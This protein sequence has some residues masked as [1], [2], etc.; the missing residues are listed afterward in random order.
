MQSLLQESNQSVKKFAP[1]LG[2][3]LN[4]C[5]NNIS[6]HRKHVFND[7][8]Q[9]SLNY[10]GILTTVFNPGFPKPWIT[11]T[12]ATPKTLALTGCSLFFNI[13]FP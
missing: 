2:L 6:F 13:D 10:T 4:N 11:P 1:V 8:I 12:S 5:N 3:Q 7:K 9:L